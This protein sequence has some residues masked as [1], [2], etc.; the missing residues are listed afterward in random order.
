L[1]AAGGKQEP[2]QVS[3]LRVSAGFFPLLGAKPVLGRVF[4]PE[5]EIR[6]RDHEVILS[7]GLWKRRYSGDV[8]QA[9]GS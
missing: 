6:G 2:E 1:S 3:G 9:R 7:Y 4:L 8:F 5:E